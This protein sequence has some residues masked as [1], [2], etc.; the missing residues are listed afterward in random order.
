MCTREIQFDLTSFTQPLAD[1]LKFKAM[2]LKLINR[3]FR[4]ICSI[5]HVHMD[6]NMLMFLK[7]LFRYKCFVQIM[8][9]YKAPVKNMCLAKQGKS[10]KLKVR[11]QLK[12]M[13]Y[14]R[15]N[16]NSSSHKA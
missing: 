14:S 10:L 2:M 3:R 11:T 15:V 6:A 1:F 8:H 13:S 5:K 12:C 4:E 9:L 16:Y 7:E